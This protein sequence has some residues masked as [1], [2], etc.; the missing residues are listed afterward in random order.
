MLDCLHVLFSQYVGL[1]I[2]AKFWQNPIPFAVRAYT[3]PD[4]FAGKMHSEYGARGYMTPRMYH[5]Q[6]QPLQST[7]MPNTWR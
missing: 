7:L 4:L 3:L 6:Q 5:S 2:L 1:D